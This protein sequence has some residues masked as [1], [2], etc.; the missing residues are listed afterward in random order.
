MGSGSRLDIEN[1]NLLA[2]LLVHAQYQ[3]Y[4]D[5]CGAQFQEEMEA[6]LERHILNGLIEAPWVRTDDPTSDDD[7][8]FFAALQE[9]VAYAFEE[10][11][12]IKKQ[13]GLFPRWS[14]SSGGI[15]QEM[16]SLLQKYRG[17]LISQS[18]LLDQEDP[19][20]FVVISRAQNPSIFR[21]RL[22]I[23]LWYP[24]EHSPTEPAPK[25][26]VRTPDKVP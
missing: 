2:T 20:W 25:D 11:V 4:W 9:L 26:P 23:R 17:E 15:L 1:I 18:R 19:A 24:N 22:P 21:R 6:L 16:Q 3:G 5:E 13:G 7:A 10:S 8:G 14:R 12:R